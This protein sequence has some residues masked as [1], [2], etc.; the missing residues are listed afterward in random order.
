VSQAGSPAA[1]SGIW[2]FLDRHAVGHLATVDRA[3]HPH[4]VPICFATDGHRIYSALDEKPKRVPAGALRRVQNL[5]EHPDVALVV[6]DY[7]E[8]WS[9]LAWVQ[10]RGRAELLAPGTPDQ[11]AAVQLLRAKY[12]QYRQM[13]LEEAPVIRI[14][15]T[16]VRS[17]SASGLAFGPSGS[18]DSI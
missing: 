12:P 4:V 17:W 2:R 5:L 14:E 8:D 18:L 9:R 16:V 3:G 13:R 7:A 11:R 15:P 1:D 10:V 6:D